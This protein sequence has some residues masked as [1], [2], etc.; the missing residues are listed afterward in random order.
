M[1]HK[2]FAHNRKYD[3]KQRVNEQ[4]HAKP[5]AN[6]GA[7]REH[8]QQERKHESDE[9][10][11]TIAK[12]DSP[13]RKI[14]Y[15]KPRNRT[16]Q[17]QAMHMHKRI[18]RDKENHGK[19][20]QRNTR[21]ESIETIKNIHRIAN[22]HNA[23]HAKG[24][25]KR[26]GQH[27]AKPDID[28]VRAKC[29]NSN[30]RPNA[31]G[32]EAHCRCDFPRDVLEKAAQ[33]H[34]ESSDTKADN[35][36]ITMRKEA[37]EAET[38]EHKREHDSDSPSARGVEV[39][40]S[41]RLL[42]VVFVK[43]EGIFVRDME[44]EMLQDKRDNKGANCKNKQNVHSKLKNRYSFCNLRIFNVLQCAAINVDS[45]LAHRTEFTLFVALVG[46]LECHHFANRAA[47]VRR[48]FERAFDSGR[49][50]FK[51]IFA[52]NRVLDIEQRREYLAN[53][54]AFGKPN[55]IF[56]SNANAKNLP[57]IFFGHRNLV[58]FAT[59]RLYNRGNLLCQLIHR[60]PFCCLLACC[61]LVR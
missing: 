42:C 26:K 44:R 56:F 61:V 52:L 55:T 12:E 2:S 16:T 8:N 27:K 29:N 60:M 45:V 11:A 43:K 3:L 15:K 39:V 1:M 31:L 49:A 18:I 22:A 5:S 24:Q 50:D 36:V 57:P 41:L 25:R 20:H 51:K 58:E 23:E 13:M 17:K 30:E 4:R 35:H 59:M 48:G 9:I 40:A 6:I 37:L 47:I 46:Q 28:N 34:A 7:L 32:A 54:L 21:C 14:A 38:G 33:K 10:R 53:R 19:R